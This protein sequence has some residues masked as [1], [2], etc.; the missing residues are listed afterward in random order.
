LRDS[1]SLIIG[2]LPALTEMVQALRYYAMD[3]VTAHA[4][5]EKHEKRAITLLRKELD[6]Y[7]GNQH[8]AVI[9]N[10]GAFTSSLTNFF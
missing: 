6:H 2:N 3:V 8:A 7:M 10:D 1:D 5:A 9:V 4:L